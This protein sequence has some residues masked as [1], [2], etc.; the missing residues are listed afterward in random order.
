MFGP[1]HCRRRTRVHQVQCMRLVIILES[2]KVLGTKL[3]QPE[4]KNT[5]SQSQGVWCRIKKT[6]LSIPLLLSYPWKS[7]FPMV[8]VTLT[9]SWMATN[10]SWVPF[11]YELKALAR[12]DADEFRRCSS[13]AVIWISEKDLLRT[14]S[15]SDLTR[16]LDCL[17]I[18]HNSE[19]MKL[20]RT[21]YE[22]SA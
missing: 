15:D 9:L 1:R 20:E 7:D 22:T 21:C 12:F 14:P 19:N 4:N 17:I 11:K 8:L 10:E 18:A 13:P 16:F 3:A 5:T 6:L 2:S